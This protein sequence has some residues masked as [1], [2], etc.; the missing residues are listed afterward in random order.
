M[1]IAKNAHAI[2]W[3]KAEMVAHLGKV[4]RALIAAKEDVVVEVL[5]A[6]ISC[7]YLL[8]RRVGVSFGR[9]DARID[10]HLR[11]NVRNDHQLETWY[12]DLSA[13]LQ[14]RDEERG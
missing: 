2:E 10:Q 9:L 6:L 14:Y 5:A 4:F 3:L 13:L 8:A 12:G 1:G 7:A 11:N